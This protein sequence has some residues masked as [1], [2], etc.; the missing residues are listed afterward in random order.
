MGYQDYYYYQD[1]EKALEKSLNAPMPWIGLYVAAA[2]LVCSLAMAAD[3]IHGIRRRKFWFPCKFFPMNA[4]SLT[5]LAV[6]M[7]LP[8]DLTTPVLTDVDVGAK[9]SSE[10]FM[11][12]VMGNFLISFASRNNDQS[13]MNIVALAILVVTIV[14]DVGIQLHTAW[15]DYIELYSP[16]LYISFML[17]LLVTLSSL[18]LTN[19]T[20]KR[21][22]E[23]KYNELHETA[24][25]GG[26]LE[27]AG[28]LTHQKLKEVVEKYWVMAETGSPQFVMARL[29]TSAMLGAICLVTAIPFIILEISI[30]RDKDRVIEANVHRT[31]YRWSTSWI[32]AIQSIGMV[33][34]TIAPVCRWFTAVSINCNNIFT[35]HHHI[36]F[37]LVENFWIQRLVEWKKIPL[38]LPIQGV[39]C[40]KVI[41]NLKLLVLNLCIG[42]QIGIVVA[43]KL[44][45]L[46]SII[47]A[48]PFFSCFYYCK[49]MKEDPTSKNSSP[50]LELYVLQLEGEGKLPKIILKNIC[51][52]L[53]QVIQMGKSQQPKYL[54]ELLRKSNS[55][56]KGVADID[57]SQVLNS[58]TM[59]VVTLTSIAIALP[60]VESQAVDRLISSVSEGL[61]YAGLVEESF[62]SKA[63]NMLNLKSAADVV[64][65]EVEL[66][67]MWLGKD[68][69]K[70]S[71]EG[72]TIKETL[73]T[74][75]D[76][77]NDQRIKETLQTLVDIAND[78]RSAT[79]RP[80]HLAANSMKKISQTIL[81]DYE[82]NTDANKDEKLFEQLS[83]MIADNFGA[84]LSNL[85][86]VVIRK[87]YCSATEER[88]KSVRHAARLL[89]E[90]EEILK[91]L[92]NKQLTCL[93][94][95]RAADME[96][97]RVHMMQKD[98]SSIVPSSN[99]EVA[100]S[101][102]GESHKNIAE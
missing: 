85:S 38:T 100:A 58:W 4:T 66:N 61:V 40:K 32:L 63:E 19:P 9:T 42:V 60:N 96:E 78:Q 1:Y 10:V 36:E 70:L 23:F 45:Q 98:P 27:E 7:K 95:D 88:E 79:E 90:I 64:W 53:N 94:G 69:R 14:V 17:M 31:I 75:V 50:E 8:V 68:L 77:A 47:I 24:C 55:Y 11:I 82:G 51:H 56:Y 87:C 99:N 71:L 25:E 76:I 84:C 35:N 48:L 62:S 102:S 16:K 29:V 59:P 5:I 49:R 80:N 12:I 97:G 91:I 26:K 65:E 2:S 54:M 86:S 72:K 6:A 34:G 89:G 20:T 101:G 92:G 57:S 44:V 3:V 73:Q 52:E 81:E 13:F 30:L 33:L 28:N 67:R 39:K 93:S 46:I 74:L 41:R 22:M 83:V 18:A 21:Y 15:L 37:K 43:S